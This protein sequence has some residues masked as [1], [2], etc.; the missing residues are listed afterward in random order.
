MDSALGLYPK[1]SFNY[2]YYTGLRQIK[3]GERTQALTVFRQLL[4]RPDLSL[5]QL[6]VTTS[7]LSDIYINNGQTDSAILLLITAA[8][9]V[10]AVA[11]RVP[12]QAN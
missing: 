4:N 5:H 3:S 2:A 8:I 12:A 9:S 1:S 11:R 10:V 6:A 7:T